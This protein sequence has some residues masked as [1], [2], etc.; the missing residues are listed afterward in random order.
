M[1]NESGLED[2]RARIDAI[3]KDLLALI[4]ERAE[5]ATD[6]AKL[7]GSDDD[8]VVFYRPEREAQIFKLELI[9]RSRV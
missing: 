7:K 5:L 6:V 3:D 9:N 2:V 8:E 1:A 4:S